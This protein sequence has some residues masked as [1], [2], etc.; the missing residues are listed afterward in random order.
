MG[1]F[2]VHV[3]FGEVLNL[4]KLHFVGHR[5]MGY[6]SSTSKSKPATSTQKVDF[7]WTQVPQR[8][9]RR[10]KNKNMFPKQGAPPTSYK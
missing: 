7:F 4:C 2:G 8:S 10:K 3:S 9:H 5:P 1:I 6:P